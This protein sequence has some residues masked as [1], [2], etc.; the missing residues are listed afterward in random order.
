MPDNNFDSLPKLDLI[1]RLH[2]IPNLSGSDV[3]NNLLHQVNF[4]YYSTSS[5][6]CSESVI[7]SISKSSCPQ[8]KC[9]FHPQFEFDVLVFLVD[10]KNQ[11]PIHF[12][13]K[14]SLIF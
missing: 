5:F 4:N 8:Y 1:S 11:H 13:I 2:N 7:Q 9:L 14:I 3:D 10:Y 12:R 6:C